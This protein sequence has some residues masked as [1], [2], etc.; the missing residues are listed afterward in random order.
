MPNGDSGSSGGSTTVPISEGVGFLRPPKCLSLSGSDNS[1]CWQLWLQ[2]YEWFETATQLKKKPPE[3]QV[4]TFMSSIG[5]DAVNIFNTFTFPNNDGEDINKIKDKFKQYFVPKLNVT[6]ERYKFN[7]LTQLENEPFD[8]FLTKIRSQSSLCKFDIIHDSILCDKIV[9]GVKCEKLRERLL[10]E[11]D[12]VLDKAIQMC[13]AAELASFQLNDMAQAIDN[14]N[15][16][17]VGKAKWKSKPKQMK[18][19][20]N[21]TD[22]FDCTRCGTVHGKRCCPAYNKRCKRCN[23]RGHF[24]EKC[25]VKKEKL[26]AH[27]VNDS[28]SE[29]ESESGDS[30]LYIDTISSNA[31]DRKNWYEVIRIESTD[32]KV[33]LDSGAHCNVLSKKHSIIV[34]LPLLKSKTKSIIAYS[35]H[36]MPV[37]G[38]IVAN[39]VVRN[40]LFKI[41]FLVVDGH[42]S[43]ILGRDDCEKTK[44]ILRV[45]EVCTG[46][47]IFTGVGRFKNF[48]Y[49]IDLIENAEFKVHAA[50]KIPHTIRGEVKRQ[51]DEMVKAGIIKKQIEPT[52]AVSPMVVVKKKGKIRICLDPTDINKNVRRRHFP[53]TTIE[54]IS[55]RIQNSKFFTKLDCQKGFWQIKLSDRTQKYLT[56]ATPWGRFSY[57]VL[58]F[59]L[60][61]APEVFQRIMSETLGDIPNVEVSM[62]DILIHAESMEKL[63]TIQAKVFRKLKSS[64]FTLNKDKCV[65]GVERV[66]F[67]GHVVSSNGLEIDKSKV[68]AISSFKAPTNLV[69]LQRFLGM[70]QYLTKF[71][72]NMSEKTQPLRELLKS[73]VEWVWTDRQD[74]AFS[75][76]KAMLLSAPVLKFYDVTQDVV[77]QADASSYALG[78][79]LFQG[80]R[81]VAYV[82]R[83]LTSSEVNYAQIEKEALAIKFA[84]NKFHQYIYGKNVLVYSDH[85]PLEIIF[86]KPIFAAPARLQRIL[87]DIARYSLKVVYHKGSSMY[88]ADALSR[89][90]ENVSREEPEEVEVLVILS[91][92]DVRRES[93]IAAT[94]NDRELQIVRDFVL[95]GWPSDQS[96]L[97]TVAKNYW[98]FRDEISYVDGLLFKGQKVIIPKEQKSEILTQLHR[99]HFGIQKT[100]SIAREYVFWVGLTADLT[101]FVE[102]CSVCQKTQRKNSKEPI[103]L[104]SV[105]EFPFE[106]VATDIFT[107]NGHDYLLI[108][109]SYSGY[110]DFRMLRQNTSKEVIEFLKSWFAVHGIPA[111]LESDNGP[112]Y[113]S[114]LFAKFAAEWNFSHVTSSPKY[115]QSNGLAE[116]FVQVA[117]NMLKKCSMDGSDVKLALL[118]YR[119]T[120]RGSLGSPNQR[121][122]SRITRNLFPVSK[123]MLAPKVVVKVFDKMTA[124]RNGQKFFGDRGS[125]PAPEMNVGDS[126]RVQA[127][128][129]DWVGARIIGKSK[130]P[131][132]F[133]VKTDAGGTYRRN[134]SQIRPTKAVIRLASAVRDGP[135]EFFGE[136]QC[137]PASNQNA[138]SRDEMQ[139][140]NLAADEPAV[141]SGNVTTTMT[142][143]GRIVRPPVRL[144]L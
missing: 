141:T 122:M 29:N 99:G 114:S 2:Q 105:P 64:G 11:T 48:E 84:C 113:S 22:T 6:Y 91:M 49:D 7:K 134:S 89:D 54:E 103:I 4:A 101:S 143:S 62:D 63:S 96:K 25:F 139:H 83:A 65:F 28:S 72:K 39:T 58:P 123:A 111:K 10:S 80:D 16:N 85:K 66:D 1:K 144:D 107:V 20:D 109:D 73:D 102:K 100:L 56:F 12:L 115:P 124:L 119:N 44:L 112:H 27:A 19:E 9:I 26:Q 59:G 5:T 121:L 15:V 127:G 116:R 117:K 74:A 21:S 8:E 60:C 92:S 40:K 50:R 130:S 43:P 37:I 131:R 126:V 42:V 61:S 75:E 38:K 77:I 90:C 32:I 133:I 108:V 78:A 30:D 142:R 34:G 125:K 47:E 128:H 138:S 135:R 17:A 23:K 104:K 94:K 51:L 71:I 93:I 45:K 82:S 68:E 81:P 79:A 46:D 76:I 24:A 35:G 31:D 13:K 98:N 129:R 110:F 97:P 88:V 52:D 106:I 132:S 120:P 14:S 67:L 55:S 136:G 118:N 53:L 41:S 3:I 69:E 70:V 95:N 36:Q 137:V 18:S 140:E 57:L 33:K 87:L 86:K